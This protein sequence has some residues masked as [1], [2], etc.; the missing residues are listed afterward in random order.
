MKLHRYIRSTPWIVW[1]FLT[2]V[3]FLGVTALFGGA[4]LIID[5]SGGRLMLPLKW[6]NE[7][8]FNNYL[9]PG[10]I[11]FSIL[12]LGSFIVMFGVLT[13]KRWAWITSISI[14]VILIAWLLI[15]I[16]LIR[17]IHLLHFIYGALAV[18][19]IAISNHPE[20]RKYLHH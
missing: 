13:K 16:Y 11:L 18:L 17:Q 14:G 8:P 10:I 1:S 6:L 19:L 3:L 4:S 7:T 15:Q 2:A 20:F 12:G 9:I 5:P